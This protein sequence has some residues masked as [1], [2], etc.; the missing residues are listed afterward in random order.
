MLTFY[1]GG[2]RNSLSIKRNSRVAK[3][4]TVNVALAGTTT[5]VYRYLAFNAAVAATGGFLTTLPSML[6]GQPGAELADQYARNAAAATV[7]IGFAL[8]AYGLYK[9]VTVF[10]PRIKVTQKIKG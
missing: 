6:T 4:L 7:V 8:G 3:K 10:D 2:D 5:S 9:I 1:R